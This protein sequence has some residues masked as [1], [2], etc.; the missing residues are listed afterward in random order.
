[1]KLYATKP[2]KIYVSVRFRRKDQ[3]FWAARACYAT[4][5]VVIIPPAMW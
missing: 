4:F 1:M 5:S 2:Q 3:E